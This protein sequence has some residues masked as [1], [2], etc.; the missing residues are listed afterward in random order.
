MA[1]VYVRK[2]R[3]LMDHHLMPVRVF[4]R[5]VSRPHECVLV[6]MMFIVNIAVT[7]LHRF[8]RV[9]IFVVLGEVQPRAPSHEGG[10]EPERAR[11]R[12]AQQHQ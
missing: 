2:V 4:V 1:V 5:L 11:G 7:V 10:R 9:F 8:M 3:V 12:L 6:P